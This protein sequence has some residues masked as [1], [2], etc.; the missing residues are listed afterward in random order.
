[1]RIASPKIEMVRSSNQTIAERNMETRSRAVSKK[2][3]S[4]I[5]EQRDPQPFLEGWLKGDGFKRGNTQRLSTSS[6]TAAY[7]A[8]L[9]GS[10]VGVL[11]AIYKDDRKERGMI[12]GRKVNA[13]PSYEIRFHQD[14]NKYSNKPSHLVKT[15]NGFWVKIN[16]IK[17]EKFSSKASNME[18]PSNTYL[19]S[20]IVHNCA[21]L[22][23]E[24]SSQD[25]TWTG[26]RLDGDKTHTESTLK[27]YGRHKAWI[28]SS[29]K[30]EGKSVI[31][32]YNAG[33]KLH[34]EFFRGP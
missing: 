12:Q 14:G 25:G 24:Y 21:D 10:R 29:Y 28:D 17:R 11:P 20:F 15:E 9:I 32:V 6:K 3:P 13:K 27:R 31:L 23:P 1:M 16:K 22:P 30:F 5:I 7:Q 18:T 34:S 8:L 2:I 19:L 33:T 4:W 26:Y